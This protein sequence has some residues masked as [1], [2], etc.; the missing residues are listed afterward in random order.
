MLPWNPNKSPIFWIKQ[1]A[2]LIKRPGTAQLHR[3]SETSCKQKSTKTSHY[4][5]TAQ[6]TARLQASATASHMSRKISSPA[7]EF[8]AAFPGHGI[9][10]TRKSLGSGVPRKSYVLITEHRCP[11]MNLS[12]LLTACLFESSSTAF[13]TARSGSLDSLLRRW[14]PWQFSHRINRH[15]YSRT[16]LANL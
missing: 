3:N 6:Q 5:R 9:L 16:T 2:P 1:S 14:K 13:T 11:C 4:E 12:I 15:Q 7:I 10:S 8:I